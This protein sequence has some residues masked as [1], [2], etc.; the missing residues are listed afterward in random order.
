MKTVNFIEKFGSIEVFINEI[1]F[2][3]TIGQS[4]KNSLDSQHFF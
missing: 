4:E 2:T 3:I 1:Q